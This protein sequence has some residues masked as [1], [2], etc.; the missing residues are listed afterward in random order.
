MNKIIAL[1]FAAGLSLGLVAPASASNFDLGTLS[2]DGTSSGFVANF[3]SGIQ[4]FSDTIYF[5]LAG[6]STSLIGQITDLGS[7]FGQVVDSLNFNLDLFSTADTATS[8]GNYTD[9]TGTGISF[10]YADLAA[11]DYFFR[12]TGDSAPTGNAYNYAFKVNVTE[13][14]I[15]PAL[16]L[17]GTALGGMGVAAYR[18]RKAVAAGS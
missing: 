1:L 18:K 16:L 8:L 13:T 3:G 15:P 7:I 2:A 5:S 10:S 4:T 14:P 9:P 12:I 17:F 11:G 6:I